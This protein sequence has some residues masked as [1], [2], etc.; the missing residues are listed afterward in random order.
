MQAELSQHLPK[1]AISSIKKYL[2]K[3]QS[4]ICLSLQNLD[5]KAKFKE[6]LWTN[7]KNSG[8][9]SRILTQGEVFDKAGVNFSHVQASYLP[10]SA[11]LKRPELKDCAYN[12][13]GVSVVVHPANPYV[14]TVHF[15]VRFFLAE[16]N[17]QTVWWFGGGFD[18]TPYYGFYDDCV[19]WHRNA[20]AAC[21][22]FGS[23]LY[24]DFK[25]W[26]DRYF[27]LPHRQEARGI[28]GI[29]F[30]DYNEAGFTNCFAF[31][32][33][34]GNHFMLGYQPIVEKRKNIAYAAREKKFQLYRRGRYVEFNLIYDRGTL[35]GLQSGGRTESILMSLPPKVSWEYNW[36]PEINS[37]EHKLYKEFLPVRDWLA[38]GN[39]LNRL[40]EQEA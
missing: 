4:D 40:C 9:A 7:G 27:Y 32:Q 1:D 21:D 13:L 34:V 14:P 8:G 24:R 10:N 5:G 12:A 3:L 31:M 16:K 2:Y 26:C 17:Q 30:D 18:L 22:P 29:F 28:G 6:E 11:S 15:N 20:K 33:S 36:Q 37:A 19:H 35:F 23:N 39:E 38:P 25:A